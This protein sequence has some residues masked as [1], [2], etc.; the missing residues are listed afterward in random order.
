MVLVLKIPKPRKGVLPYASAWKPNWWDSSDVEDEEA[1]HFQSL[2]I[3][4]CRVTTHRCQADKYSSNAHGDPEIRALS[5]C[6][7]KWQKSLQTF[8]QE[9][10][11]VIEWLRH[12]AL[13]DT[14]ESI[15]RNFI[16]V[17]R[18]IFIFISTRFLFLFHIEWP[19]DFYNYWNC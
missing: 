2:P 3:S 17:L 5:G 18:K 12:T 13:P 6:E 9:P 8:F 15:K 16:F 11:K 1:L 4:L 19:S 10:F 14:T 7:F